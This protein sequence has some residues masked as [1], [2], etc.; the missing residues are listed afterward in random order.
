MKANW[1]TSRWLWVATAL[2]LVAGLAGY[3]IAF[4][5]AVA[6]SVAQ[7]F[8]FRLREGSLRAFPVQV[9]V[10]Y[11]ALLCLAVLDASRLLAMAM[12]IGTSAQ[13]LLSYCFLARCLSLLPRNRTEPLSLA[14]A[15]RTLLAPAVPGSI[16][17]GQSGDRDATR[18]AY[19]SE[20][21]TR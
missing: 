6:L 14:L 9:R 8:L 10:A 16:L 11:T 15:W 1:D 17:Q 7:I 13:V 20:T 18:H 21:G 5:C 19:F 3:E 12:L 2:L 4:A